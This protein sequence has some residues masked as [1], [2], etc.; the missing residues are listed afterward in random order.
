MRPL[1]IDTCSMKAISSFA[2]SAILL[3]GTMITPSKGNWWN[4]AGNAVSN[5][6]QQAVDA[7]AQADQQAADATVQAGQQ[8][9][10]ATAQAGQ[11][12]G[13]Y[14]TGV[15]DG[16]ADGI[17]DIAETAGD[18]IWPGLSETA[19]TV[20]KDTGIGYIPSA[21]AA[22]GTAVSDV[23]GFEGDAASTSAAQAK[24]VP[25]VATAMATYALLRLRVL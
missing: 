1:P 20:S 24:S 21:E 18:A 6:G 13:D 10:D 15:A 23:V 9:A 19:D 17:V 3:L 4:D 25:L 22:V 12:A 8:A 11:G 2:L 7:T 16:T 5:A 14:A